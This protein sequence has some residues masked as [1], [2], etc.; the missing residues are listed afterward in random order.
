[1]S[2]PLAQS[3]RQH[4]RIVDGAS[5]ALGL[6]QQLCRAVRLLERVVENAQL[7]HL[8]GDEARITVGLVAQQRGAAVENVEAGQQVS[9]RRRFR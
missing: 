4:V 7:N 5:P 1:M 8:L 9:I 2:A 3:T 6:D